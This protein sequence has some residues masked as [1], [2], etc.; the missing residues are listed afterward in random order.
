MTRF[1]I[2]QT[3]MLKGQLIELRL[4][5]RALLTVTPD[6]E[7][8]GHI[9]FFKPV[10][11]WDAFELSYQLYGDRFAGRGFTTEAVQP[12]YDTQAQS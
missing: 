8:V 5:A 2:A 6:G 3:A 7:M 11:Y 1:I 9:E 10:V 12:W 4:S